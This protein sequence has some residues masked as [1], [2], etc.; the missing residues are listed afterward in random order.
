MKILRRNL[1]RAARLLRP[2]RARIVFRE[3]LGLEL[4]GFPVDPLRAELVLTHLLDEGLA[5]GSMIVRPYPAPLDH[6]LRVH[7]DD[8]LHSLDQEGSL[9][10]ILGLN[11]DPWLHDRV[12]EIQRIMVTGSL[13]AAQI[14]VREHRLA[15][16]LGGGLHHAHADRGQGFC[17][18]NDVAVAITLLREGGFDGRI[19]LIDLDLHD[20]DGNRAF[21]AEDRTVHTFSLHNR[22][23]GPD[24]AVESTSLALDTGV[25]DE[26]YLR[27]LREHLPGVVRRFRPALVFYLAGTDPAHDDRIGDWKITPQGMLARD[28]FVME[29]LRTQHPATVILMAGGYGPES[30]RYTARFLALTLGQDP[31]LEP[32]PTL[33]VTLAR[34]RNLAH[35]IPSAELSGIEEGVEDWGLTDD[36]I[37]PGLTGHRARDCFL[38]FYTLYGAELALERL[39]SMA[40]YRTLGFENP[41]VELD[42]SDEAGDTLRIFSR[43]DR[44]ELIAE[45]R[46]RRDR[47]SVP[48]HEMLFIEW[49]LLQ[50]PR[51]GFTPD[52]P[53]LPGQKHP[54]LGMLRD[55][56]MMLVL[57]CDRLGLEGVV[58]VP[59]HYHV[60]A[61]ARGRL[62]FLDPRDEAF[63][64]ALHELFADL[65]LPAASRAV[66]D[67][68]VVDRATGEPVLWRKMTMVLAVD[69][70]LKKRIESEEYERAVAEVRA[71]LDITLSA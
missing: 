60:A 46:V 8:Y 26:R 14:A 61:Q 38:G 36:D 35:H 33:D 18:F 68:R 19:L 71:K 69:E 11:V 63:F 10:R 59:S 2:P 40:R 41:T 3:G 42:L 13:L 50:N 5:D 28:R 45:L 70:D 22:P 23:W 12:L 31:P 56:A 55:V 7:S 29:S 54:G 34:Y 39:G 24:E 37:L 64:Q 17:V 58:F 65:D 49:L 20:G 30:W 16:H 48:G 67:G 27:A 1:R 51:A 44:E 52:R 57:I 32:P 53:R 4:S 6:L 66:H 15:I 9:T 47:Q 25:G 21:F 62:R 43:P